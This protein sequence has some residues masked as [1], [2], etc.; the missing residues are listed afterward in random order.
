MSFLIAYAS[1]EGQSHKISNRITSW[2]QAKGT[3]VCVLDT[4]VVA[5]DIRIDG[6][7]AYIV[8]GSLHFAKHQECLAKFVSRHLS[9]LQSAPSAFISVSAT[10]SR[11]DAK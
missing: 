9:A 10:G 5:D 6:F 7:D 1:N 2:L 3:K 11:T 8:I 4:A